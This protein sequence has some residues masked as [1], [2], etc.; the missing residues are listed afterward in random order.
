VANPLQFQE[1]LIYIKIFTTFFVHIDIPQGLLSNNLEKVSL[2]LTKDSSDF[3]NVALEVVS[4][5][6]FLNLL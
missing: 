6:L 4:A 5:L 1:G 3:L 2:D